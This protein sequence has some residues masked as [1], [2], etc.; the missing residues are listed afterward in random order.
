MTLSPYTLPEAL[1]QKRLTFLGCPMD[2]LTMEE[3]IAQIETAISQ[4]QSLQHVVVNV[5]KLVNCQKDAALYQ[6]VSGSDLINI[7]GMGVV[8][9]ARLCG[10]S[11]PERVAGVDLMDRTL[12][13]CEAKGYRPYI[14]GAKPEVLETAKQ[15]IL[16]KYPKLQFAGTQHGYYD[17]EREQEVMQ[18]IRDSKAD[19]LFIAISSPH[20]ERLMGQYKDMLQ[21]PFIMGVGGSVDVYAGFVSRAPQWMQQNGLEWL[22]RIWQEPRRMWKRYA[23]TNSKFLLLLLKEKRKK[24]KSV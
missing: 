5:A 12:A 21:V 23:I 16:Q 6:D 17:R 19:C 9:G 14:L 20:K 3:S 2:A 4:R 7:D 11:V 15:N 8:W 13:L 18:A 22:Y 1:R 24:R 10:H